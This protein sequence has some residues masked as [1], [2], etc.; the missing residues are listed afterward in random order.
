MLLGDIAIFIRITRISSMVRTDL[1]LQFSNKSNFIPSLPLKSDGH[2]NPE[3]FRY[4]VDNKQS[5]F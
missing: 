1:E 3:N 5:I 2:L 4:A